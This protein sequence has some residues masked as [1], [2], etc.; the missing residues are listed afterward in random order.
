[1]A[2][3]QVPEVPRLPV[4]PPAEDYDVSERKDVAK[5]RRHAVGLGGVLFLTVTG[6]AQIGRAHV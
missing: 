5:L 3:P 6:S 2:Q 1:M 4:R